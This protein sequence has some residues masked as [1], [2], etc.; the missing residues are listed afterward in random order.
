MGEVGEGPGVV[1]GGISVGGARAITGVTGVTGPLVLLLIML[2]LVL[3]IQC[4]LAH[5]V[6]L[7]VVHLIEGAW[8]EAGPQSIPHVKTIKAVGRRGVQSAKIIFFK[9][10]VDK[11]F[12]FIEFEFFHTQH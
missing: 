9:R 2:V 6:C 3:G 7:Y 5:H 1:I 11:V 8:L 12:F 10:I 4:W